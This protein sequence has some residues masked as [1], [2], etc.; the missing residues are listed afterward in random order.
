[1]GITI[2][3]EANRL[4]N[5]FVNSYT[6]FY[7]NRL[8]N[9]NIDLVNTQDI[10]NRIKHIMPTGGIL[11]S[12]ISGLFFEKNVKYHNG[13]PF[14]DKDYAFATLVISSFLKKSAIFSIGK[15]GNYSDDSLHK[16]YRDH[17]SWIDQVIE[18][19]EKDKFKIIESAPHKATLS[20]LNEYCE[21]WGWNGGVQYSY[22]ISEIN[23]GI[24]EK[25]LNSS[26]HD[27]FTRNIISQ[28]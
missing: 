12:F 18:K 17:K 16:V 15:W 10:S 6:Y 28:I 4:H 7:E 11:S 19:N 3:S 20:F 2:P 13:S 26:K 14:Q 24:G 25:N 9:N 23:S 5:I 21:D 8:L 22:L 1:M 27:E